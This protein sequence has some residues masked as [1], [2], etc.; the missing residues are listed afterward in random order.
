MSL[1]RKTRTEMDDPVGARGPLPAAS[2][3][4][5][6][7]GR[8][9]ET[10]ATMATVTMPLRVGPA[11]NGRMMTLDDFEEAD[12]EEGYRYEL[13]RGVLEVSEIPGE[14]HAV[15]VWAIL[16]AIA[17]YDRHHPRVIH[18]AGGGS[19]YRFRLP[20]MQSGRH[21]DVAVTLRNT[22][23]DWRGFRPASIAFEVVSEGAEARQRDYVTK[24]AEYLAYGL[25]EYRIVDPQEKLVT[26]LIR[27]GDS[28]R[29]QVYRDDQL[30]ES[31][32]LPGLALRVSDL[33]AE[34]EDEDDSDTEDRTA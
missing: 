27:D 3:Q 29:E 24:R 9:L 32:V 12:F 23:R 8:Y 30:A 21:P 16:R 18:R 2:S 17:D 15:I 14:L 1:P 11:D 6:R 19:E 25:R 34:V 33:W 13:A 5:A 31:L 10:F 4:R 22:P 7:P 26:V 28:W 20:A